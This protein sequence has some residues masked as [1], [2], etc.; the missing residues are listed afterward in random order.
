MIDSNYPCA[1]CLCEAW[2][3]YISIA[4]GKAICLICYTGK[5]VSGNESKF[6]PIHVFVPDNLRYLE[7]K[8]KERA[9]WQAMPGVKIQ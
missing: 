8:A 3:H 2:K 6:D 4:S 5:V 9:T 1:I 7:K